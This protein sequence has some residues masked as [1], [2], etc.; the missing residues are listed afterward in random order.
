M[1]LKISAPMCT[2]LKTEWISTIKT[3]TQFPVITG[4]VVELTCSYSDAVFEGSKEVTCTKDTDYTFA[5]EAS[6]SIQGKLQL[7]QEVIL[8]VTEHQIMHYDSD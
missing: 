3:T 6:C 5:D 4:T 2:G 7:D 8:N 1:K